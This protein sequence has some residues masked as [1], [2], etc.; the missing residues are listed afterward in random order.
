MPW[1]CWK[2]DRALVKNLARGRDMETWQIWSWG[3][4]EKPFCTYC[5]QE[6]TL[7]WTSWLGSK[8]HRGGLEITCPSRC[9]TERKQ[10][11]LYFWKV[12][13]HKRRTCDRRIRS[14]KQRYIRENTSQCI[15]CSYT[16]SKSKREGTSR[17]G[18]SWLGWEDGSWRKSS[19]RQWKEIC[20]QR[21]RIIIFTW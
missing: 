13:C 21:K 4:Q 20:I 6:W 19:F 9:S 18:C 3:I 12:T 16:H 15:E 17:N 11:K 10:T 5:D 2:N 14:S 7:R 1:S 8:R